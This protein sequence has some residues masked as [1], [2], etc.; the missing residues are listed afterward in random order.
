MT[1]MLIVGGTLLPLTDAGVRAANASIMIDEGKITDVGSGLDPAGAEIL[2][3]SGCI[4][5]PGLVDTHRHTW[6]SA[7]RHR[8]GDATFGEYGAQMLAQLAPAYTPEDIYIGTLLGAL[9][10]LDSGIT[11]MADWSHAMNSPEHADAAIAGLADA[12]IR[13]VFTHGYPRG[14]G[15]NWTRHSELPHPRDIVRIRDQVLT[16]N[17]GL[18]TLAMAARGPEMTTME[19]TRGDLALARELG[20]RVSLHVGAGQFGPEHRAVAGM[21]AAGLLASDLTFIHLSSS[22]DDEVAMIAGSGGS[23]SLAPL[24]EAMVPGLGM[25]SLSRLLAA[26]IMPSLSGDTETFGTGDLFTQMRILLA[27][28]R[29]AAREAEPQGLPLP[30]REVLRYATVAGAAATG[31]DSRIGS[32]SAGKDADLIMIRGTDVNLHPV[33]DPVGAVVLA[34][35]PGNVD[36]VMVRGRVLKRAGRLTHAGLAGVIDRAARSRDRL[37][38]SAG[39]R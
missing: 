22:S 4:V 34:A 13:A 3:A 36:T 29:T 38:S 10:A 9:S 16:D 25:S 18:V 5:L 14:D 21:H 2:D 35:H 7:V 6:Q 8:L 12:G 30:V 15:R 37:L 27:C 28:A 24:C 39:P 32:L 19:T 20:V 17:E 26:G 1:R 11:T 33:T 23:V 31:L